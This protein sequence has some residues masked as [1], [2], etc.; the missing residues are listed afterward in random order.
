MFFEATSMAIQTM[1]PNG[2]CIMNLI[3]KAWYK[4][5]IYNKLIRCENASMPFYDMNPRVGA[6]EI[7]TVVDGVAITFYSKLKS[8]VWPKPDVVA[9]KLWLFSKERDVRKKTGRE[10]HAKYELSG[11]YDTQQQLTLKKWDFF[12]P[13]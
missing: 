6:F 11:A 2:N 3:P 1:V 10:L 12:L 4:K 13:E 8:N 9:K 7:S 5:K